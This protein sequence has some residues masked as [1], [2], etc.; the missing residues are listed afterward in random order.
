MWVM[1]EKMSIKHQY[2]VMI[3]EYW[4]S[5][6]NNIANQITEIKITGKA[7]T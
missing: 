3:H 4:G 1:C 6:E 5:E 2:W 7:M